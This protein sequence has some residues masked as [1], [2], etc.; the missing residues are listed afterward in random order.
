MEIYIPLKIFNNDI[1]LYQYFQIFNL[2]N[3]EEKKGKNQNRPNV[4]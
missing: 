2:R 3:S 4:E 1:K